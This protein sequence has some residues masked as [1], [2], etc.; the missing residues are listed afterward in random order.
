M[1]VERVRRVR[2]V[3]RWSV[4]GVS[5]A[6]ILWVVGLEEGGGGEE[7]GEESKMKLEEVRAMSEADG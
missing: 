3:E 1:R 7:E 4:V 6:S 5:A 2:R